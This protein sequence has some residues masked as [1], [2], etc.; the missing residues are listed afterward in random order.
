[1]NSYGRALRNSRHFPWIQC[2]ATPSK[3]RSSMVN[4]EPQTLRS[5]IIQAS[6]FF[7]TQQRFAILIKHSET[8]EPMIV[9]CFCTAMQW[10]ESTRD[11]LSGSFRGNF[12]IH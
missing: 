6:Q 9:K 5:A 4:D 3:A 2:I 1:M 10:C 11:D 8:N 7:H 12:G